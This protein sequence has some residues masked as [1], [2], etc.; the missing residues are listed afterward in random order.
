MLLTKN[1]RPGSR[2]RDKLV[3]EGKKHI[4][5]YGQE[6]C[7][8]LAKSTQARQAHRNADSLLLKATMVFQTCVYPE[9]DCTS[10][11]F[12]PRTRPIST[13]LLNLRWNEWRHQD[14]GSIA[15]LSQYQQHLE[16]QGRASGATDEP[17][18]RSYVPKRDSEDP[19]DTCWRHPRDKAR[20]KRW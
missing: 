15:N 5:C 13:A 8:A 14:F 1:L 17:L 20:Y 16:E 7:R 12:E 4:R 6:T 2:M 10:C 9:L 3:K 11:F 19:R 18:S